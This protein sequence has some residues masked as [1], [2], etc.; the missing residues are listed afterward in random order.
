MTP[1]KTPSE[2]ST[3][4]WGEGGNTEKAAGALR[5]EAPHRPFSSAL[6]QLGP[7][8]PRELLETQSPGLFPK[9]TDQNFQGRSRE[10][11]FSV[12]LPADSRAHEV[13]GGQP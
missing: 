1:S 9:P 10:P 12:K 11:A 7:E 3:T 2:R 6:I 5:P 8:M 13:R 4:S